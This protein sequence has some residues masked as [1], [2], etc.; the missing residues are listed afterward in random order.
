MRLWISG[1]RLF[2]RLIHPGISVSDREL[3]AFLSRR[4]K[5]VKGDHG[6]DRPYG[7]RRRSALTIVG[8]EIEPGITVFWNS[9]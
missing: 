4:S 7:V 1:P 6:G 3:R 8:P 5:V 2:G 9:M